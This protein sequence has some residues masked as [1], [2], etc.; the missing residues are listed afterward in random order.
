MLVGCSTAP[1]NSALTAEEARSLAQQ[2]ANQEAQ[3]LYICQPFINPPPAKFVNGHWT[4]HCLQSC[5]QGDLDATV[6]FAA[7]GADPKVSVSQLDSRS[8]R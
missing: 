5:G 7:N 1:K 8:L 6:E 4:W 2:L 3:R